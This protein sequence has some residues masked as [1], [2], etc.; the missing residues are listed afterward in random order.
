MH[1]DMDLSRLS[2]LWTDVRGTEA[3]AELEAELA[4]EVAANHPLAHVS[5]QAV[6][7]RKLRKEVIYAVPDGRWVWVHLT[8]TK[9]SDPRWP[10]T[11]IVPTW[12]ELLA[13]LTDGG[14][15]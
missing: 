12:D 7:V 8:W 10:S 14:R 3:G 15:E 1:S 13:E 5:V 2:E 6:A 9:E 11:V 4:R